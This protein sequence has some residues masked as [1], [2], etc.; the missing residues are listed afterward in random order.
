MSEEVTINNCKVVAIGCNVLMERELE[1]IVKIAE[2]Q[3][4]NDFCFKNCESYKIG[5]KINLVV[6]PCPELLGFLAS[7]DFPDFENK[8]I[9]VKKINHDFKCK[10][11]AERL[12]CSQN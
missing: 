3:L 10:Y 8:S 11:N 1:E 9:I 6:T 12:I 2:K 7:L 5:S 4:F